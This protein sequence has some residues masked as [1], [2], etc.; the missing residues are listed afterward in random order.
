MNVKNDTYGIEVSPELISK[1]IMGKATVEEWLA[2]MVAMRKDPQV[3]EIV[4]TSM[5]VNGAIDS[6]GK[7]SCSSSD[8][9]KKKLSKEYKELANYIAENEHEQWAK[10]HKENGWTYGKKNDE[11][12]KKS[13]YLLPYSEL[14]KT[15]QKKNRAFAVSTLS[16]LQELGY[17]IVKK[18]HH[19]T[20]TPNTRDEEGN[21][22]PNPVNLRGVRLPQHLFPITEY[23]ADLTSQDYNTT[24]KTIR[25]IYK[26]GYKIEKESPIWQYYQEGNK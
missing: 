14:K 12:N 23:I 15:D 9:F 20:Y 2:V 1:F 4:T 7:L 22:I 13:P 17:S 21:Y 11:I 16:I 8:L 18:H 6:S 5:R 10:I 3:M 26:L 24:K 25:F 19:F